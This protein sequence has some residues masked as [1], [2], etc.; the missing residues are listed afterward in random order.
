MNEYT[1]TNETELWIQANNTVV[2][3]AA[4]MHNQGWMGWWEKVKVYPR[5]DIMT[6]LQY[7]TF[8]CIFWTGGHVGG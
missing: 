1:Q 5:G 3:T 4:V 2:N 6:F 8:N 7:I